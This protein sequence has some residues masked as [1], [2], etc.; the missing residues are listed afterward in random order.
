MSIFLKRRKDTPE[1]ESTDNLEKPRGPVR[2]TVGVVL[3]PYN[4]TSLIKKGYHSAID[5]TLAPSLRAAW[6][7]YAIMR[8]GFIPVILT[9]N[10]RS[11]YA[12][13]KS[14]RKTNISWHLLSIYSA[15]TLLVASIGLYNHY[16]WIMLIPLIPLLFFSV[17][18]PHERYDPNHRK[19]DDSHDSHM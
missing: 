16:V 12:A 3:S 18:G 19:N 17:Y 2:K 13:I 9:I 11:V 10:P 7:P 1:A 4:P 14:K 8:F 6:L 5:K 15:V